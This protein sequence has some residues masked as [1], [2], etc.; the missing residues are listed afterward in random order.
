[1]VVPYIDCD[2]QFEGIIMT[3]LNGKST[4]VNAHYKKTEKRM[5]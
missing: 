1:V 4:Q 3:P 2:T 5:Q